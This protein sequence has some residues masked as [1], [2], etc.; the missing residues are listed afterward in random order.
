MDTLKRVTK[1]MPKVSAI[2]S[3]QMRTV[4]RYCPAQHWPVFLGQR[5]LTEL[6]KAVYD[7]D[8]ATQPFELLQSI[9]MLFRQIS[10]GF[11][12][13][14]VVT[15]HLALISHHCREQSLYETVP[16]AGGKQDVRICENSHS[17]LKPLRNAR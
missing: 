15:H 3:Q 10:S 7:S 11:F 2:P 6:C 16:L 8:E 12:Q 13:R 14:V 9:R 17:R 1:Q 4:R 5:Q